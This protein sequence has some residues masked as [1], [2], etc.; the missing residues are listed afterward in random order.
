MKRSSTPPSGGGLGGFYYG[1]AS[2]LLAYRAVTAKIC[3]RSPEPLH[4]VLTL[5]NG[6]DAESLIAKSAGSGEP[7]LHRWMRYCTDRSLRRAVFL[8]K[9]GSQPLV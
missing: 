7:V 6:L 2:N 1:L 8:R 4:E 3:Q 5:P 9:K